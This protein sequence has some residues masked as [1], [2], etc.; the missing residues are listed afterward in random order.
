MVGFVIYWIRN[1]FVSYIVVWYYRLPT[2]NELNREP[3]DKRII[4]SLT[5]IPSRVKYLPFVI[6]TILRQSMKPDEILVYLGLEKFA[7]IQLPK[8]IRKLQK[9][10][11]KL[12]YVPD[13]KPH[14]KWYYTMQKYPDDLVILIDDDTLYSRKRIEKL[15]QSYLKH[16]NAISCYRAE[17]ITFDHDGLFTPYNSW[18]WSYSK[19]IDVPMFSLL[20]CAVDGILYPP[21]SIHKEAFNSN[22]FLRLSPNADDVW[23]KFMSVMNNTPTVV[24]QSYKCVYKILPHK[25]QKIA[26]WRENVQNNKND[27]QIHA[28]FNEYNTY[29]GEN[30][31]LL[32]K[33]KRD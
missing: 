31:T 4:V 12:V 9:K 25:T 33:L 27:M 18:E 11:V 8:S 5:T 22:N 3:R 29:F 1:C 21:N 15:Y 6:G 19:K 2:K 20:G 26:L 7:G 14:T 17:K 30:D 28:V 13:V 16:P 32:S 10:G 24:V 23:L